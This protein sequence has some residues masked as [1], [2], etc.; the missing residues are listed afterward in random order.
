MQNAFDD[1]IDQTENEDEDDDYSINNNPTNGIKPMANMILPNAGFNDLNMNQKPRLNNDYDGTEA[2]HLKNVVASKNEEIRNIT[3]EFASERMSLQSQIDELKK[4]LTIA[5]AEKE[6]ANMNRKQSYDLCVESKQKVS[7]RDEQIGELNMKIKQLDASKLDI[8]AELERTKTL[9]N[10]VQHKYHMVERNIQSERNTD[11]VVKQIKDQHAAQ[12]DMMQQQINTM[13]T[14]Y[15]DRDSEFKRLMIQYN[16]L[17]KSREGILYEKSDTINQLTKRLDESQ[18]QCQDL[19]IRQGSSENITQETLRYKREIGRLEQKIGEMQQTI[20]SLTVRYVSQWGFIPKWDINFLLKN[21]SLESTTTDLEKLTETAIN[22][23]DID[24]A[25]CPTSN[26]IVETPL[27]RKSV[28]QPRLTMSSSTPMLAQERLMIQKMEFNRCMADL[29]AKQ[30]ENQALKDELITKNLQIE[31]LKS[32]E[33]QALIEI[34]LSK[35]NAERLANRLKNTERELDECQAKLTPC[36]DVH[37][38]KGEPLHR[39]HQLEQENKNFRSNLNHLNETIRALED[40]RDNIEEKYRDAC[41]DIAELQQKLTKIQTSTAC[42]ECEKEKFL[43]K[44]ARQECTRLKEMYI[45][46]NDEK[47]EIMRKLRYIETLDVNKELLEQ[48]N[49]VASLE[50][51]L[52]LAEMKYTEISKILEREKNDYATQMQNL[53][54]KYEQGKTNERVPHE[55]DW[56]R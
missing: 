23:I 21:F 32:D 45:Q 27:I 39:L 35:E 52:Q 33:N 47:E 18:R 31:R 16:E 43:A 20:N 4:R 1:L 14:K 55:V 56:Q 51:S 12:V 17:Q 34:T 41:K 6:R 29:K 53:R 38:N 25:S 2:M 8:V 15:E 50:R 54:T 5:E 10:D 11:S 19:I 24:H 44:D 46:I 7:E 13:R 37:P 49:M 22:N 42:L 28:S 30:K 48:R 26:G 9:L 40:E 36:N 3:T